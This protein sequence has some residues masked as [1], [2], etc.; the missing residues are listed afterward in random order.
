M[1]DDCLFDVTQPQDDLESSVQAAAGHLERG[2]PRDAQQGWELCLQAHAQA[3]SG[4]SGRW[5]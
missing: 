1:T 2:T 3:S 4:G 5:R